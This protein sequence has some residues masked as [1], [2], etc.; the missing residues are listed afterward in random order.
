[1]F[2]NLDFIS[3]G[4]SWP[5]NDKTEKARLVRYRDNKLLFEGEHIKVF[6]EVWLRL[7]RHEQQL[8]I[9][10]TLNWAKR[11]STLW[12]DLL[13]GERPGLKDD[14]A[15]EKTDYL[16]ELSEKTSLWRKAYTAAIDCSRY[17]DTV[18][19]VRRNEEGRVVLSVIPPN[20]WFPV[21]SENDLTEILYHVLAWPTVNNTLYVEIHNNKDVIYREYKLSPSG[22]IGRLL[23]ERVEKN[24]AG[25][26][27]VV[28][29]ANLQRSDSL[30]GLD[31][32]DD[33]TSM[34]QELEVRFAQI[35]RVLDA[36]ADPKMFGP[37]RTVVDKD[38]GVKTADLG[39]YIPL[40][41]DEITPGY[42]T[43]DGRLEMSF[44]QIDKIMQQF[45]ILSETSPAVFGEIKSGLAESGS[46][47]RRLMM[48]PL[49]K[50]NR[51]RLS[52]DEGIKEVLKVAALLDGHS[53]INPIIEWKD[54][55]PDDETEITNN[56]SKAVASGLSSKKSAI[57]RLYGLTMEQ[58][59][60]ELAY[61]EEETPKVG[62]PDVF[63]TEP[64]DE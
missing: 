57:R 27:Y 37:D 15:E 48:A 64:G 50:V 63:N 22:N 62:D 26:C 33:L 56:E 41:A 52:F 55:L 18:I 58:A 61:I 8:S 42:I 35:A 40:E 16:H 19:K 20:Y 13:L 29:I 32:Y 54:G 25:R 14:K 45:Y 4:A 47:L 60:Q 24:I 12:A 43:W 9:E 39:D 2:T 5:P 53:D 28:H 6:K 3:T 31:D 7:F 30:Y 46:A 51:V 44:Q 23:E 34:M 36:H 21:V 38:T 59:E 11:I 17:G 49:A 10:F 1:M